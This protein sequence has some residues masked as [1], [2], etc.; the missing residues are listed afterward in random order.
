[1]TQIFCLLA[2]TRWAGAR[3]GVARGQEKRDA[4]VA[5]KPWTKKGMKELMRSSRLEYN[6]KKKRR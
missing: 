4:W 3:Y 5:A 2:L 6:Q 1:M